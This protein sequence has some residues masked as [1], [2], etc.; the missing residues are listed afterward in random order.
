MAKG[1]QTVYEFIPKLGQLR[2][3]VLFGD[4]WEHP[5]LSKRDR[6]LATVAILAAL[7]RTD[8]MR[9]HMRRALD[10]GVTET[11]LKGLITH[12]AF[13]AGWPC[14]VNAGRIAMEVCGKE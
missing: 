11:E 1:K 14:A 5:D 9:G 6:S 13:Y 4:V 7:Y 2:D 12:V 8:E 3:D 10:N